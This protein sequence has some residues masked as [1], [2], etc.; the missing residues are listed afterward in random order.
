MK[1]KII[2]VYQFFTN[3]KLMNVLWQYLWIRA[4]GLDKEY[5]LMS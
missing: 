5:A 2:P 1:L 3:I 4:K